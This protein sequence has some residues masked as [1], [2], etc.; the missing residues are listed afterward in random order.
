MKDFTPSEVYQIYMHISS[1]CG[2]PV[3]AEGCRIILD[4]CKKEMAKLELPPNTPLE[5]TSE[6]G[7]ESK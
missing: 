5:P 1:M 3:A 4:F 6:G 7:V 2:H